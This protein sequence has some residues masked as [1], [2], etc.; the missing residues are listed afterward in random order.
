ACSRL[1][2]RQT[3]VT[4]R[5]RPRHLWLVAS[6][7]SLAVGAQDSDQTIDVPMTLARPQQSIVR[8]EAAPVIDGDLSD[9]AWQNAAVIRNEQLHQFLP[10]DHGVPTEASEFY[11]MYDDDFLYIGARLWDSEPAQI[12]ARQLVQGQSLQFDDSVDVLLDPFGNRRGGY[13]FQ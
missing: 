13:L 2:A 10:Q 3:S 7:V 9:L 12:V 6:M 4:L 5:S 8:T 1:M 11:L